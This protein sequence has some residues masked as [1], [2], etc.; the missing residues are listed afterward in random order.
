[1][2][3]IDWQLGKVSDIAAHRS[4]AALDR[5]IRG[6]LG[7][8]PYELVWLSDYRFH[9]RLLDRLRHG[10]IFF[11][12]DAAHLVAPFGARGMNS[13]IHDVENLGWKLAWVLRGE[14][15]ET[16]LD[17]YDTERHPAL[18][19][20]QQITSATMRFMAPRT[21]L[22][23]LRRTTVLRLSTRCTTARRWVNSGKMSQPFT[24][25]SS[26]ILL[27]DTEPRRAW[28]DAPQVGAKTP[29][30]PCTIVT[31]GNRRPTWL[32]HLVGAGFLALYFAHSE[33]TSRFFMQEVARHKP[34]NLTVWPVLPEIPDTPLSGPVLWDH[35]GTLTHAFGARPGTLFL[36]RPDGHL[37]ARRRHTDPTELIHLIQL[38]SGNKVDHPTG[39]SH[40]NADRAQVTALHRVFEPHRD[41]HRRHHRVS[42]HV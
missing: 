10:R 17:T 39:G 5:R 20:D 6:L 21:R 35:T 37:A 25:Q 41:P 12:G 16:L 15:P 30:A 32:R 11:L 33:V 18:R 8:V 27:P 28:L 19:R 40:S 42:V 3:R 7:D 13:A 1:M 26:P 31:G 14:A 34:F 2:W 4:P 22:Q 9:Q 38:A 23:R 29:D 24:Y 36:I